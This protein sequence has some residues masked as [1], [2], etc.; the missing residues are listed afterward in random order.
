MVTP[1]SHDSDDTGGFKNGL[2]GWLKGLAGNRHEE[3]LHDAL[4]ELI[5]DQQPTGEHAGTPEY[6]LL[7]NILKLKERSVSDCMCPRADIIA[8]EAQ[9]PFDK[10][11]AFITEQGHS[12]Y[13]VYRGHMDDVVGMIHMK[14]VTRA[15]AHG[16]QIAIGDILRDVLYVPTTMPIMKLLMQMRHKRYNMAI[17]VDEYGGVDGLVTIE[18]LVE[19]IVGEIE[20]EH[21]ETDYAPVQQRGDGA[22][23]VDGRMPLA[24]LETQLG[25]FLTDS[26][27]EEV[28]TVN[29]LIL[30]LAGRVPPRGTQLQHQSG[31]LIDIVEADARRVRRARLRQETPANDA[32]DATRKQAAKS[33]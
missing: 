25:H 19:Q 8:V 13:P 21:D 30:H 24:D 11:V 20:D 3:D 27:R 26:E 2:I 28:E 31:M 9:M 6:H 29:G 15:L 1:M 14:D 22:V 7:N 23:V 4:A 16:T 18:D 12:R 10:L 32:G 5:E 33:V 17:V